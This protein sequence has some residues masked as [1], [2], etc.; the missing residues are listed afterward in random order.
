MPPRDRRIAQRQVQTSTCS[1]YFSQLHGGSGTISNLISRRSFIALRYR[2]F[3]LIWIG[4][5]LSFTG[6]MM[7]NAGLLWHVSLLV[8]DNKGLALGMVGL[9][10]VMPIALFS[11]ISGVLADAWDRRKLMLGTQLG[12]TAVALALA[13]LAARHITVVW[14]IYLLAG[15]GAAVGAFDLPARNA[16]VPT[17]VPREHLPNA[18]SL[19]TIMFQLS[20]VAGPALGGL[21]IA[22][23][24]VTWVYLANAI[25]F[26]AVV[27]ALLMMRDL[28]PR[29]SATEAGAGAGVGAGAAGAESGS[30]SAAAAAAKSNSRD[31]VSIHAAFEGLR[32]VFGNA[33]IRSTMLLDFFATFFSS[34][35]ALL[36][37]FAQDILHVGARGYGWLYAAPAIGAV[38]CSAAMVPLTDRIRR[39]GIVLLWAVGGYGLATVVFGFS[40]SFWLTFACLAMT[41]IT[42]T[43]SMVIRNII[44]Q[45]ETPDRLRGRM[46]GV[47]MLFFMGGPQLGELEAGVVADWLGAPISV[48]SGGLGCLLCTAFIA[49][50]TPDLRHET[51]ETHADRDREEQPSVV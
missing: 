51:S 17:L 48:I 41:G 10:K 19:N 2:N 22:T 39:R 44:R 35:T 29:A 49:T 26:G 43:V 46:I 42:D 27:A 32:F 12:A 14:P 7:Q 38:V 34:A 5:L 9:V 4:L 36:P 24:S 20:A 1:V 11:M 8:P 28:P 6:S 33:L 30:G 23:T 16:L 40:K 50:T 47:N 3:R 18:I 45:L 37:I 25:S 21:V 31:D 13:I 15:L